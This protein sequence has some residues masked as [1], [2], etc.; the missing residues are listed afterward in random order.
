VNTHL[1]PLHPVVASVCDLFEKVIQK[2]QG[3]GGAAVRKVPRTGPTPAT[4]AAADG[5]TATEGGAAVAAVT[6]EEAN[7]SQKLKKGKDKDLSA[8][9]KAAEA[10]QALLDT[11]SGRQHPFNFEPTRVINSKGDIK[12]NIR[13]LMSTVVQRSRMGKANSNPNPS[14]KPNPNP[15]PNEAGLTIRNHVLK[16]KAE[17][18]PFTT[19]MCI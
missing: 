13:I 3:V 19:G 8:Q 15:N 1:A 11:G 4:A 16:H 9:E 7:P 17:F 18:M 10:L 14:L 2:T 12:V 6:K 5:A